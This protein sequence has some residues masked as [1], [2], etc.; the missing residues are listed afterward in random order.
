MKGETL[1]Q[2]SVS[3]RIALSVAQKHGTFCLFDEKRAAWCFSRAWDSDTIVCGRALYV[4]D[5]A[6]MCNIARQ[7]QSQSN[8][9]APT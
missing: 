3:G 6:T 7:L 9:E 5:V 8:G 2:H 4:L 1:T